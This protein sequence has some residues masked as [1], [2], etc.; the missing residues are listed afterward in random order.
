[1]SFRFRN[2]LRSPPARLLGAGLLLLAATACSA[3]DDAVPAPG[4]EPTVEILGPSNRTTLTDDVVTM[5]CIVSE[6]V[7]RVSYTVNGG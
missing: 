6:D 7:E 5:T 4:A 2:A 1:M 3:V